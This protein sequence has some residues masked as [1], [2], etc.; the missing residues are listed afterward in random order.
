MCQRLL[1]EVGGVDAPG[2]RLAQE[3]QQRLGRLLG[4]GEVGRRRPVVDEQ[5][6]EIARVGQ[7]RATEPAHR[8]DRER[9]ARRD[10][11]ERG[12]H[13]CLRQR[14]ELSGGRGHRRGVVALEPEDVA[15]R[16]A[17]LLAF[18]EPA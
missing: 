16:D 10:R 15:R 17:E 18:L 8:D 12:A 11:V 14:G 1:I 9:Q 2:P 5:Q 4:R 13:A 6:V 3:R 7:L